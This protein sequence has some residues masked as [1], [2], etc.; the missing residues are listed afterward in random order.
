M[1]ARSAGIAAGLV[2]T[3]GLG[4]LGLGTLAPAQADD[5]AKRKHQADAAVKALRGDLNETS[6]QLLSA[7]AAL[8]AA[9]GQL[10]GAQAAVSQAQARLVVAQARDTEIAGQLADA[11]ADLERATDSLAAVQGRVTTGRAQLASM[12][13]SAYL[14]NDVSELSVALG[15]VS[16]DD[17]ATN[18]VLLQHSLLSQNGAVDRLAQARAEVAAQRAL[19]AAKQ[20]QIA[21]LKAR[22]AAQVVRVA[23]L[24]QQAQQAQ[25]RVLSLAA[26][27]ASAKKAVQAQQAAELAALRLQQAESKRLNGILVARARAARIAAAQAAARA[28]AAR[29]V[30]AARRGRNSVSSGGG[31]GEGSGQGSAIVIAGN[32]VLSRPADGPITSPYGMRLHPVTGVYKLHDGTD[33]GVPC[34]SPVRAAADGTVVWES[35]MAGYGNQLAIDEGILG[36]HAIT[37]SYSH[38][39]SFA[40]P[41]GDHVARGQ[42]IAYSG[43][44]AG[45]YGA[46]SSTGCH[47][48]FMVMDQ[49]APINVNGFPTVDPMGWL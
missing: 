43:G 12:A 38:L 30:A 44:G 24:E 28:A 37:A 26:A 5:T 18:I 16:P 9:Q 20:R 3:L 8:A 34:G 21:E 42:L 17:F 19:L 49:A 22:S 36:G 25:D 32:G 10:P 23:S 29:A 27:A 1:R 2:A 41:S 39:S 40:V 48:H 31:S 14:N 15:S 11:Q 35:L 4:T 33:F 47:V 7:A 6:A 45:M 46:G 13:R